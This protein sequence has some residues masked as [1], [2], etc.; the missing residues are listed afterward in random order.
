M[1]SSSLREGLISKKEI[2]NTLENI[3]EIVHEQENEPEN[4]NDDEEN[5]TSPNDVDLKERE[6]EASADATKDDNKLPNQTAQIFENLKKRKE[7][8]D[9][10]ISQ[11][12]NI[13]LLFVLPFFIILCKFE[14]KYT[15]LFYKAGRLTLYL[16]TMGNFL[17][18]P[19]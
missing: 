18:T 14:N 7:G 3:D 8:V 11:I 4:V 13:F 10:A 2:G 12:N 5:T 16:W 1:A 6:V 17:Y 9:V 19:F 15:V